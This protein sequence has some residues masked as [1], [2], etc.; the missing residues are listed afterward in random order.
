[1]HDFCPLCSIN[2]FKKLFSKLIWNKY[3]IDIVKCINCG[4]IY[5]NSKIDKTE[6]NNFIFQEYYKTKNIGSKIDDRFIRH[7][8]RRANIHIKYLKKFHL[9]KFK[10]K[11]LDVGCGAGIYLK[12][13]R[14]NGWE[15]FG[16]EPSE[17]CYNYCVD[18]LG[19]NVERC[20]FSEYQS[21]NKFD[22]IY[23]SHIFDDLPNIN[24]VLEKC[25]NLLRKKGKIFI[26]VP[27]WNRDK[28]FKTVKDGDLIENKYYFTPNS[29]RLLLDKNGFK[30][31][32]LITYEP[33][34]INTLL[35]YFKSPISF[36]KK[37]I[38]PKKYKAH[39]RLVALKNDF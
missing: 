2:K 13:M 16:I 34:Y 31:N 18:E 29:L 23:F 25:N 1:M 17:E 24:L 4:F 37:I 11:V 20:L 3:Q 36:I 14:N 27:N 15:P 6:L 32:K 30:V 21:N 5:N 12:E 38:I 39:I 33:I 22:L 35:Q 9:D 10:G 19:I 26:E 7:F 28:N 8:T